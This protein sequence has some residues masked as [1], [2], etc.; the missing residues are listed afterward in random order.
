MKKILT[1]LL[2]MAML[3]GCVAMFASCGNQGP[4]PKLNL[5]DAADAL[6]DEDYSVHYE[7]DEDNLGAGVVESLSAYKDDDGLYITKY[8]SSATAK[9]YFEKFKFQYEM[10][11]KS[12]KLQIKEKEHLLKKYED[13]LDNDDIDDLEDDIKDLE[14]ELEELEDEAC[15]GR[16]GKYVW[17]GTKDAIKDSKG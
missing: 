10:Q 9:L 17:Y 7:D 2:A 5:E 13:D 16:S 8:A 4:K 15:F 11:I 3:L 12:I 14:K 6:E 1:V